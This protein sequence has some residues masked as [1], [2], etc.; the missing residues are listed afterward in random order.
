MRQYLLARLG[1]GAVGY[2]GC[3]AS[4]VLHTSNSLWSVSNQDRSTIATV[5]SMNVVLFS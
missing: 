5:A 1:V 2:P 3:F 4:S